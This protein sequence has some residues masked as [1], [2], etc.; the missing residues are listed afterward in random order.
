MTLVGAQ[1]R[2]WLQ[3]WGR[4]KLAERL[5]EVMA[6]I[7]GAGFAGFETTIGALPLSSPARFADWSSAAGGLRLC[8]AHT[9]GDWWGAPDLAAI[10]ESAAGLP[11][12]GCD[13]LVV[14]GAQRDDRPSVDELT[15]F[16]GNLRRLAD[17]CS[18]VGVQVGYHN[19][20]GELAHDALVLDAI[21]IPLAPDLGW[22]AY[23]G[24]DVPTF[25]RRF[26]DRMAYLHVRDVVDGGF[27]EVGRG[28]LDFGAIVG[29]LSNYSGW[30]VAESELGERWRGLE[31][32]D[33]TVRAQ[34]EG[35]RALA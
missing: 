4:E 16:A 1:A 22:V 3:T 17:E 33:A 23:A 11:G 6:R 10:V 7:A 35:L 27:T 12:L 32:P 15:R 28:R 34:Y 31:D 21:D 19:H 2:P 13:R 30:W 26:A 29:E 20:A 24:V 25:V 14:S 9:G 18:L 8:A 5:G